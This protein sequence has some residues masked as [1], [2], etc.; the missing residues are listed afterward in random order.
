MSIPFRA[1]LARALLGRRP[2]SSPEDLLGL[3]QVIAFNY[4]KICASHAME[5]TNSI[6]D[7]NQVLLAGGLGRRQDLSLI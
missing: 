7:L 1:S 6:P 5:A 3:N 4:R 2:N